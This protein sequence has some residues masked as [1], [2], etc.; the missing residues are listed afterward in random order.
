MQRLTFL[1]LISF[2]I[3]LIQ[4]CGLKLKKLDASEEV[5]EDQVTNL[6]NEGNILYKQEQYT[7]ALGKFLEARSIE[8]ERQLVNYNIGACY[9]SLEKYTEATRAFTDEL[10]VDNSDAYAYIFR[11]HSYAMMGLNDQAQRDV[12]LSLQIT[13]HAMSYYV[14]GLIHLN[15]N[16]FQLAVNKFNAAIY[17]DPSDFLYYRDRG[18]AYLKLGNTAKACEDFKQA[19]RINS[20][21]D[22]DE[23]MKDCNE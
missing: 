11:A 1:L 20:S 9:F 21:V 17:K 23:E 6:M 5:Q 18:K 3:S 13:D 10:K 19:R 16:E 2:S 7:D 14:Q 4:S 15:K 12:D 22:L 8:P